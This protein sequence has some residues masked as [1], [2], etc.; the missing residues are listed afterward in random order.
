MTTWIDVG[1]ATVDAENVRYVLDVR[2]E[3]GNGLAS[4]MKSIVHL[5]E[6]GWLYAR[7]QRRA[8]IRRVK[9]ALAETD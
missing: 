3:H 7:F 6:G 9:A 4:G 8:I 1:A 2:P 5:K